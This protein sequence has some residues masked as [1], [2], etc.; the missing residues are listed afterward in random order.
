MAMSKSKVLAALLALVCVPL[1]AGAETRAI[2]ILHTNDIHDHL[3]PGYEGLGG[4][5][6]VAGY[7]KDVRAKQK[8]TLL[9]DAGD[10]TEKGDLVAF[11]THSQL[12]YEL[13]GK[14]GYDAVTIGNHDL[15]Q[16]MDALRGYEK[17]LGATAMLCLNYVGEN[18]DT[19]FTASKMFEVNGVKVAVIGMTAPGKSP[20]MKTEDCARAL[21]AEA[22]LLAPESDIQVA[23]CHFGSRE[24]AEQSS[25]ATEIDVFVSGH[26]HEILRKPLRAPG[27]GAVIVQA[28]SYA[29]NVGRLELTVDTEANRVV[30]AKGELVEMKH[31]TIPCDTD[32]MAAI[33][34]KEQEVCPEATRV[35]GRTGR[36]LTVTECAKLAAVALR[37]KGNADVAFCHQGRIIRSYIPAGDTDVNV[38]FVAGGQRG[39]ELYRVT[40]TGGQIEEYL[41]ELME[42]GKG[43][44]QWDGFNPDIK[45]NK[46][47]G[48]WKVTSDLKKDKTY[49]MI[50]P[51]LEWTSRFLTVM[52]DKAVGLTPQLCGFNWLEAVV[53]KVEE[54]TQKGMTIDAYMATLKVQDGGEAFQEKSSD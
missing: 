22:L 49:T 35:V 19:P 9:L 14:I 13:L 40:L 46:D 27:S 24:C 41:D 21:Q 26:S 34:S 44:S 50:I 16:G 54:I 25:I 42:K 33:K 38:L 7:V 17:L 39:N 28:G 18:G 53:A 11:R 10:V 29:R 32:T 23:L 52:K 47:A 12:T 2:T 43:V 20:Q 4:L 15:D 36:V 48:K 1:Y 8:D 6:Y 51:K 37:A 31:D 45:P 3:R 5:P 30:E